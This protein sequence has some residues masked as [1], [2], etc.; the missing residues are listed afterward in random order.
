MP[1]ASA[2]ATDRDDS[3]PAASLDPRNS[4]AFPLG[5]I[6]QQHGR[7]VAIVPPSRAPSDLPSNS[8]TSAVAPARAPTLHLTPVAI[9]QLDTAACH[10]IQFQSQA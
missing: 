6:Q 5:A 10:Q 8:T 7:S 3:S 2:R 4:Q 9:R 1:H